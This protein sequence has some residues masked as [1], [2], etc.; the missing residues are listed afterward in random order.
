[1]E[2]PIRTEVEN[3]EINYHPVLF[4]TSSRLKVDP[5]PSLGAEE[6]TRQVVRYWSAHRQFGW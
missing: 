6:Q 2:A 5:I 4:E 1:M 3:N